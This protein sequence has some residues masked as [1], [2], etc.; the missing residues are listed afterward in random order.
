MSQEHL[1][2]IGL[3]G[4]SWLEANRLYPQLS[5]NFASYLKSLFPDRFDRHNLFR[6]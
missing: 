4:R 5:S 2:E 3:R 6:P 1:C